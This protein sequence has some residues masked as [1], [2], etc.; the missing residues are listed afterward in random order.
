LSR[1]TATS[2]RFAALVCGAALLAGCGT[3]SPDA[4]AVTP[5]IIARANG[6]HASGPQLNT[7]RNLFVG[8]CIECHSLPAIN[9]HAAEAWPAIVRKMS[10][11]AG[12]T[13]AEREALLAYILA[14]H[15]A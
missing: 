10:A 12:L 7:G 13:P 15:E 14:A 8:R 6:Q 5:S 3:T 2:A 9:E 4:P 1:R 11:R